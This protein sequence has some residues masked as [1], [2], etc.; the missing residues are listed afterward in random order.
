MLTTV[1]VE[2][3][4][5]FITYGGGLCLSS[6]NPHISHS[7]ITNNNGSYYGGGLFAM[8]NLAQP[9]RILIL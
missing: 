7:I 3:D 1:S 6:S 5:S 9:S 4:V 2:G 8:N